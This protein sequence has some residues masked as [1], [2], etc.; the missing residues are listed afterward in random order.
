MRGT[1]YYTLAITHLIFA[2]DLMLFSWGDLPSINMLLQCLDDFDQVSGLAVNR[3]KSNL[4][5]GGLNVTDAMQLANSAGIPLGDFPFDIQA[6][7][8]LLAE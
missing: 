3:N 5:L 6:S 8:F 4:Y 7:R 1:G 2:D